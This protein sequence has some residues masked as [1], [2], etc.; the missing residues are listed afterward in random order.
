MQQVT[1]IHLCHLEPLFFQEWARVFF[2]KGGCIKVYSGKTSCT[3]DSDVVVLDTL[4]SFESSKEKHT[5]AIYQIRTLPH[6]AYIVR[7]VFR[8]FQGGSVSIATW[9]VYGKFT[10]WSWI[11]YMMNTFQLFK[12]GMLWKLHSHCNTYPKA[13]LQFDQSAAEPSNGETCEVSQNLLSLKLHRKT[14]I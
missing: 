2:L 14:Y 1:K 5:P 6:D 12:S 8:F 11:L 4:L 3:V 10:R 9:G 13:I 7:F